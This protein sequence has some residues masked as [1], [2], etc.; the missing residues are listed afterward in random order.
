MVH[1][2]LHTYCSITILAKVF[3]NNQGFGFDIHRVDIFHIST[4]NANSKTKSDSNMQT[5]LRKR[6]RGP[7]RIPREANMNIHSAPSA[8]IRRVVVAIAITI[9]VATEAIPFPLAPES[10]YPAT[11]T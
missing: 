5:I 1:T 8:P 3:I 7:L 11:S 10:S 2:Q 4:T 9:A 6:H